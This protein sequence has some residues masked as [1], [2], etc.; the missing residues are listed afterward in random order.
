MKNKLYPYLFFE[1]LQYGQTTTLLYLFRRH[2]RSRGYAHL[3]D[4]I[5][6]LFGWRFNLVPEGSPGSGYEVGFVS[7][8]DLT[9]PWGQPGDEVTVS[10]FRTISTQSSSPHVEEREDVSK[11]SFHS[12]PQY[13]R[14]RA[15]GPDWERFQKFPVSPVVVRLV[16]F[17]A[18][19]TACDKI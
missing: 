2:K 19:V 12:R 13:M 6:N 1:T 18:L 8:L 7:V 16:R 4:K 3:S 9:S 17:Q 5:I 11:W 14:R 15:L 10:G